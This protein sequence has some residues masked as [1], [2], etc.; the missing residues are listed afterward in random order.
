M[1]TF[2]TL[3][4]LFIFSSYWIISRDL[5]SNLHIL[6]SAWLTLL[7]K[8]FHFHFVHFILQLQNVCLVH[9]YDSYHL[10]ELLILFL[11]CFPELIELSMFS[12]LLLSFFKIIILD[13][14][15]VNYHISISLGSVLEIIV[16][17]G[18]N[19]FLLFHVSNG[20]TLMF[21][22]LREQSPLPAFS[23]WLQWAKTFT[24][25]WLKGTDWV[26]HSL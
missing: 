16:S 15:S 23:N 8:L 25:M 6:S 20:F 26:M 10:V 4:F 24:W 9:F 19:V 2:F 7:L 21:V 1:Q 18:V 14:F 12:W 17:S 3:I 5:S 22:H 13:Y 11:H